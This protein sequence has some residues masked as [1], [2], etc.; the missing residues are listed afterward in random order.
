M[1]SFIRLIQCMQIDHV[2][3]KHQ[4]NNAAIKFN[5]GNA[6]LFKIRHYVDTKNL[7]SVYLA[8]FELHLCLVSLR[9]KFIIS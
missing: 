5:K 1:K 2:A 7:K 4:I 3:G 8:M 6:M 9:T